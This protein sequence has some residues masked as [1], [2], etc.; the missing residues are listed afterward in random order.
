MPAHGTCVLDV[1][2]TM[3]VSACFV[4]AP[5]GP[6]C[7]AG[8]CVPHAPS[9]RDGHG[10]RLHGRTRLLPQSVSAPWWCVA[11]AAR[12]LGQR[13]RL[14]RHPR[15]M[16][17]GDGDSSL[18]KGLGHR[19]RFT[20]QSSTAFVVDEDIVA[21]SLNGVAPPPATAIVHATFGLLWSTVSILPYISLSFVSCLSLFFLNNQCTSKQKSMKSN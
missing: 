18:T 4:H 2:L 8:W 20:H 5:S 7:R 1:L 21:A 11:P 3:Y 16:S 19:F 14:P 13:P 15:S 12:G 10:R 17:G 6:V 9:P